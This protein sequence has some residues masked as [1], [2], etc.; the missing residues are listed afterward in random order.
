MAFSA[1]SI[2]IAPQAEAH[3]TGLPSSGGVTSA[4][5]KQ[6]NISGT[7]DATYSKAAIL[8]LLL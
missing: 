7:L 2:W 5:T 4:Y 6:H 8:Y 3:D 1:D